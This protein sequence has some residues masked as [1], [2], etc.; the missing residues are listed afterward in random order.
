MIEL[1]LTLTLSDN[2]LDAIAERIA[3]KLAPKAKHDEWLDN[4]AA[5]RYLG[6]HRDTLRRHAA[7]G[8]VDCQQDGPG[9]KLYFRR[10]DLDRWRGRGGGRDAA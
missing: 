4:R 9:C 1:P 8:R 3:A 5:A 6:V 10:S 2:Q 7:E